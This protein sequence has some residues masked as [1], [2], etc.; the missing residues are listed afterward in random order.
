[1]IPESAARTQ[2]SNWLHTADISTAMRDRMVR[3]LLRGRCS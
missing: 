1:M 2:L 3:E